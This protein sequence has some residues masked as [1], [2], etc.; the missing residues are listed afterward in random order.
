MNILMRSK[1][2][3]TLPNS[4][5]CDVAIYVGSVQML[6]SMENVFHM[7]AFTI[8]W[9]NIIIIILPKMTIHFPNHFS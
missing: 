6:F 9:I 3:G 7:S 4:E 2:I 1:Y 5:R 8:E